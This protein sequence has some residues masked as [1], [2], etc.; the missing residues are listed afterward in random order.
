MTN[1]IIGGALLL[2]LACVTG[3]GQSSY[4]GLT[5]GQSTRADVDRVLGQTVKNVS[6]T[7][8]E[9]TSPEDLVRLFVQ[10]R[11][12]SPTAMVE[13]IELICSVKGF[14][15]SRCNSWFDAIQQ[16]YR[17][18][19]SIPDAY[20]KIEGKAL[21]VQSYYGSPLFMVEWTKYD[22][23]G[24]KTWAFYSKELF[25][26]AVPRRGCTGTMFGDW[27]T[28]LGRMTIER[29]GDPI[30]DDNGSFQQPIKGTYLKNNGT[31]TGTR[32]GIFEW[33]D[34]TGTGTIWIVVGLGADDLTGEWQRD[35]GSGPAK[36][37]LVGRCVVTNG[38]NR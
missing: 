34:S 8:I 1:K 26:N 15:S 21:K 19:M 7:L 38:G 11:D 28:N 17:I 37:K 25:E 30:V 27:E 18:D 24:A 16:K 13:R 3:F 36:G 31:F 23:D 6:K 14:D 4:K 20:Q 35:T 29:V 12:E 22:A 33:K 2:L 10:Y 32:N 5:P 9:Y